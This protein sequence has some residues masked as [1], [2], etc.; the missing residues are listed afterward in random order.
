M[1]LK[2]LSALDRPAVTEHFAAQERRDLYLRFGYWPSRAAIEGY[3]NALD[4]EHDALFGH[5]DRSL[6]LVALAHLSMG[7][8][9]QSAE[10]AVSVCVAHRCHGL[11]QS[12][13]DRCIEH[14]SNCGIHSIH[15][16]TLAENR[17]MLCI[18]LK[19]RHQM[20]SFAQER[21]AT[22]PVPAK[23]LLSQLHESLQDE[24]AALEHLGVR[25]LLALGRACSRAAHCRRPATSMQVQRPVTTSPRVATE[26]VVPLPTHSKVTT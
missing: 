7:Q 6:R 3:V 16:Q 9:N 5:F 1:L 21:L 15:I 11:G 25:G 26:A 10:F 12:L 22:V 8:P 14:A 4:F 24:M 17:P 13:L 18:V 20:Q 19:H 23:G 2:R